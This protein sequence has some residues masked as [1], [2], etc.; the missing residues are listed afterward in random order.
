MYIT[1]TEYTALTG[2]DAAEATD[3]RITMASTLLDNRIGNYP[4]NVLGYKLTIADL[5]VIQSR[6]VKL[7]VSQMVSFLYDNDDET[8]SSEN[9]SLGRFSV[10]GQSSQLM[11]RSMGYADV[12]LV[13]SGLVKRGVRLSKGY[14]KESDS[15]Y[16]G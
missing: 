7:W 3:N 12:L 9:I 2:K 15:S 5:H 1:S 8:P 6:A 11:P 14:F 4:I 13:N 10:S 16:Y